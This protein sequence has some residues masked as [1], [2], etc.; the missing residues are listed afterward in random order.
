MLLD[1]TEHADPPHP[2]KLTGYF[3][4]FPVCFS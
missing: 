4:D 2:V 3:S 1:I